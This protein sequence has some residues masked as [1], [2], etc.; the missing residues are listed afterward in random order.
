MAGAARRGRIATACCTS[1]ARARS[2]CNPVRSPPR[3]HPNCRLIKCRPT[4]RPTKPPGGTMTKEVLR[5]IRD[6]NPHSGPQR[7]WLVTNGLGGFAS[8]TVSG[9]I[10]RRY[11]GFLIA[12][13]PAPLGRVVLLNDL[14]G[15]IERPDGSMARI[16]DAG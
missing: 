5:V 13:L 15:E 7:E 1:P 10:P 16:R 14:D 8:A 4:N 6:E 2:S 3:R 11:H 9:E 12:A